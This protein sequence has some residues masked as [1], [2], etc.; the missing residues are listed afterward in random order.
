MWRVR[1]GGGAGAGAATHLWPA[2]VG[3]RG[4][5]A[6]RSARPARCTTDAQSPLVVVVMVLRV[7]RRVVRGPH[8][9]LGGGGGRGW[10]R[11]R[12]ARLLRAA[13]TAAIAVVLLVV[14][15]V[16]VARVPTR[17][18]ARVRPPRASLAHA[19]CAMLPFSIDPRTSAPC[20]TPARYHSHEITTSPHCTATLTRQVAEPQ[21]SR[22]QRSPTLL[23][24]NVLQG[25]EVR[26]FRLAS[27]PTSR[28]T[29]SGGKQCTIFKYDR[30][31]LAFFLLI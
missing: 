18:A 27:T 10:R 3:R 21:F 6:L 5:A 9:A 13:G 17:A 2:T 7:V 4:G 14:P 24:W 22:P 1:L 20:T 26:A 23:F 19:R 11:L 29:P 8:V 28:Y 30:E 12:H 16:L 25:R 15:V 31:H